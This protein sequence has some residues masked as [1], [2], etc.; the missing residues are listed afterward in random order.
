MAALRD[1]IEK[2]P[3]FSFPR[4]EIESCNGLAAE[5]SAHIRAPQGAAFPA[6][7]TLKNKD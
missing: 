1:I 2:V 6:T 7:S 4:F 5:F 3:E